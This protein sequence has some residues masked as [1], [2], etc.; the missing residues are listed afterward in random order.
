MTVA[1][2]KKAR[3]E[4]R[5]LLRTL[6]KR[7]SEIWRTPPDLA[8]LIPIPVDVIA[9][10]LLGLNLIEPE[11][12]PSD[13]AGIQIAGLM[14]RSEK[15]IIAAQKY[16]HEWRRF[17]IA[18]EIGHWLL[19][20]D[21]RYHRDRPL[22]GGEQANTARPKEEQEADKFASELLMPSRVLVK[23]FMQMFGKII[24][25]TFPT[26][27]L[28]DELSALSNTTIKRES[29]SKGL[30]YRSMLIASLPVIRLGKYCAPLA[31]H[32]LVSP[33][34]MAIQLEDLRLVL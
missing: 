8:G 28:A 25:G 32:F 18:H 20:P 1:E 13:Q 2:E 12:I 10:S 4:A 14:D 9:R 7:R 27:A 11:E 21:V 24:D 31:K 30:R 19:H 3:K 26:S 15:L 5:D 17:T 22:N 29:F 6:W 23:Y 34:A 16:P 33:T